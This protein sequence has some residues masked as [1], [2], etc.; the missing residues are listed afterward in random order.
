[1]PSPDGEAPRALGRWAGLTARRGLGVARETAGAALRELGSTWASDGTVLEVPVLAVPVG[2]EARDV[3]VVCGVDAWVAALDR[4]GRPR[5]RVALWCARDD[6]S[7]H[8]LQVLARSALHDAVAT[9]RPDPGA[10]LAQLVP[11]RSALALRAVVTLATA[12]LALALVAFLV[13][14][15]AV[16]GAPWPAVAVVGL[17][18]LALVGTAA[19]TVGRAVDVD[20]HPAVRDARAPLKAVVLPSPRVHPELH[21]LAVAIAE[22][23]HHTPPPPATATP[24]PPLASLVPARRLRAVLPPEY[25]PLLGR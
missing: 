9:A 6:V 7:P 21:A 4:G 24:A 19:R 15:T 3:V 22:V 18:G 25:A 10:A 2:T 20:P 11:S 17:V 1:M 14:V 8:D 23:D 5:V 13:A 16:A 12:T